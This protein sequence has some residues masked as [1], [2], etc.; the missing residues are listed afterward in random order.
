MADLKRHL[1]QHSVED[2]I[3]I[4]TIV[5]VTGDMIAQRPFIESINRVILAHLSIE[6][7]LKYLI[8]DAGQKYK[9]C[10]ELSLHLETLKGCEP[11]TVK[12]LED[13][14]DD[15]VRHYRFDSNYRDM[16]HLNSLESYLKLAGSHHGFIN[17]RYWE[18]D[19]SFDHELLQGFSLN[20]HLEIMHSLQ[21]ILVKSQQGGSNKDVSR[22]TVSMRVERTVIDAIN[23]GLRNIENAERESATNSYVEWFNHSGFENHQQAIA[24]A[25]KQGQLTS[26]DYI[27][28]VVRSARQELTNSTDPAVQYFAD[29]LDVL[30]EQ[31]R[32]VIPDVEWLG[33]EKEQR[34]FAKTPAGTCLGIIDRRHDGL[35]AIT[36]ERDGLIRVAAKAESQIDALCYLAGL[37]TCPAQVKVHGRTETHRVVT[38][39]EALFYNTRYI[40]LDDPIDTFGFSTEQVYELMFWDKDH[41]LEVHDNVEV[42]LPD[43][44]DVTALLD[45]DFPEPTELPSA[46][47]QVIKGDVINVADHVVS[48]KGTCTLDVRPSGGSTNS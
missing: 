26:Q 16:Q 25:S 30:P 33:P 8:V 4:L 37:L 44:S 14:F 46:L 21:E 27:A 35:W 11:E 41:G 43:S 38:R 17:I 47:I 32:V 39:G 45:I 18:I 10:H 31:P 24:T 1:I 42:E 22:L 9:K 34:G 6:R 7:V 36:P 40:S 20:L 5:P 2:V 28:R 3:R 13:A 29:I 48:I 12:F 15:A 19:H 23:K